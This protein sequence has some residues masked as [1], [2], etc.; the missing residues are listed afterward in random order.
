MVLRTPFSLTTTVSRNVRSSTVAR[1]R[2]PLGRPFGLP[3]LPFLWTSMVRSAEERAS[4]GAV[5]NPVA[6][7]MDER[8]VLGILKRIE[9]ADKEDFKNANEPISE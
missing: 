6:D 5:P 9:A 8:V 7:A 3:D 2:V 4:N 1:L